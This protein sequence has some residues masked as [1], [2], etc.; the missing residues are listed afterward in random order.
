MVLVEL[1][2]FLYH[3][4]ALS[5]KHSP[6]SPLKSNTTSRFQN[7]VQEIKNQLPPPSLI[8]PLYYKSSATEIKVICIRYFITGVVISTRSLKKIMSE[9]KVNVF[10]IVFAR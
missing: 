9:N 4:T 8:P 7:I 1:L 6:Q 3:M 10:V 5:P 2:D